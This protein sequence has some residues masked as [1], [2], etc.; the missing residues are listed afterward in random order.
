MNYKCIFCNKNFI[1]CKSII[2][3][4]KPS[5]KCVCSDCWYSL[6]KE[7]KEIL[8]LS[9]ALNSFLREV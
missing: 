6:S 5:Y 9:G 2:Y 1:D 3:V 7:E 8:I 4:G